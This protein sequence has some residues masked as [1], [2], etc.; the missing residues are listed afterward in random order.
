MHNLSRYAYDYLPRR[1]ALDGN[2]WVP[3][4]LRASHYNDWPFKILAA[5]SRVSADS[6]ETEPPHTCRSCAGSDDKGR[7]SDAGGLLS[8]AKSPRSEIRA[9]LGFG[10]NVTAGT[11]LLAPSADCGEIRRMCVEQCSDRTLGTRTLDGAPFYRCVR[12]CLDRH[13][14]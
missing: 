7:G 8:N 5:L 1:P 9:N 13:G 4:Q 11:P 14:C 10:G 6:I 2:S 3:V 12:E